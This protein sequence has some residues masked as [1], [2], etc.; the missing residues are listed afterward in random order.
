MLDAEKDETTL[1]DVNNEKEKEDVVFTK[2]LVWQYT[3]SLKEIRRGAIVKGKIIDIGPKVVVVDVGYKSEGLIQ[4]SEFR[5][6]ASYS[7]GDKIDVLVMT[8][9][10]K[11]GIIVLS[12]E[13]A[14]KVTHW[15]KMVEAQRE[16]LAVKGKIFKKVKGGFMVD[17][18]MEAFL[19][20]SQVDLKPVNDPNTIL[21]QTYEFK[22]VKV[23]EFRKNI[24]LSRR[25][26]L[27]ES[28]RKEK[29]ELLGRIK[30][31]DI[32]KGLVKNITDFGVFVDLIGLDGLLHITD[33]TWGR[34]SHPSELVAV[35]DE[36]DVMILSIDKEKEK[37]SLGLKQIT[38]DPWLEV[39][40]KYPIGSRVKGRIVNIVQYGAFVELEKGVEGLIHVSELSW[41]KRINHPSEK[42]AVGDNVEA[43]I[44]TIDRDSKR[45]SLGIKQMEPNPW[46]K[47]KEKYTP[48]TKTSGKVRNLTNY[49]AFVELEEGIDGLI[50]IS[51]MSWL[52][53][54]EHPSEVL[55]KGDVVEIMVLNVDTDNQRIALGLKQLQPDPW[56][57]V[58]ERY[59]IGSNVT[60][61]ITKVAPFGAFLELE[62]G[63]EGLIHSSQ[64]QESATE[65]KEG[66]TVTAIVVN[67]SLADRKIGLNLKDT[68]ESA[69][70][71]KDSDNATE[72]KQEEDTKEQEKE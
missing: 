3:E 29:D 24:V 28:R 49:G 60:G 4:K 32:V 45:I 56:E 5:D 31:G 55:K 8:M 71:D 69:T 22:V 20:A 37:V 57:G 44:L 51:D 62:P 17:V 52:H 46:E 36:I 25:N 53:K 48:G 35:G 12:K 16:G 34:I 30:I 33:M 38:P 15:K 43:V 50:H 42:L 2:E 6:I 19:P 7:V 39:E 18:G 1:E 10:N 23:D 68:A 40:N 41:T 14:D 9:E 72:T 66:N 59:S 27:E 13:K 70:E 26:L 65:I 54:I 47:V 61:K 11:E 64:L 67:V 21:D 58:E 63:V